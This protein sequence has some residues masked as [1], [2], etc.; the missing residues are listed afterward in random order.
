MTAPAG[1]AKADP[2]AAP[3]PALARGLADSLARMGLAAPDARFTPLEGG[4]SSL[5]VRVDAAGRTFCLKGA[6]AKLKVAAEWTAPLERSGAEVA[7]MRLAAGVVPG[8]VPE[9]LGEDREGHAFAMAFLDPSSH[10]VWKAQ[11]LAGHTDPRTAQAVAR[12][13]AAIHR[14]TAGDEAC[15]RAFANDANFFALRLDPYFGAAAAAHPDCAPVLRELIAATAAARIALVHGDVS[16]KNVL[17]GPSGPVLLDAE[18]AWY[19]DPAFDA[20]FLLNHL[21][22]K[23]A[24]RPASAAGYLAC[25]DAFREAYFAGDGWEPAAALE[26]RTARLLAAMLLARVDGKSPVEYLTDEGAR[27]RVRRF[28]RSLLLGGGE[29]LAAIRERW[30]RE[31][32]A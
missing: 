15:A 12:A 10:P 18:C 14:A 17:V 3:G 4:V 11:L 13:L 20:A 22:L 21:L 25:F 26:A 32:A 19:G 28:A 9:I 16:P 6:L 27:E 5:I 31:H 29:S 7:W 8:I 2:P 1:A 24:W 23:C 30:A